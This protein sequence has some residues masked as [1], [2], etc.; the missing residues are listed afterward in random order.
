MRQGARLHDLAH[1][2]RGEGLA[3]GQEEAIFEAF[4]TTRIQGTGLGLA[5][6]QQIIRLH[7]G[8]IQARNHPD[9]GAEFWVA[10]PEA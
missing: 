10:V 3:E 7:D 2:D 5:I 9:G 1:L 6:A 4:H 8:K